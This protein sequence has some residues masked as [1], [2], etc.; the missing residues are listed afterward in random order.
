[1][2]SIAMLKRHVSGWVGTEYARFLCGSALC[3][4]INIAILIS[5]DS[6]GLGYV[7]L[8]LLAYAVSGTTGYFYHTAITFRKRARWID[9][10]CFLGGLLLGLPVW[11]LIMVV[12]RDL[13]VLHMWIA[14]PSAT[15]LMLF[16]H[17][18]SARFAVLRRLRA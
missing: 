12:L 13:L 4:T 9:Y 18:I 10:L 17:F 16:Y 15:A 14:A 3:G 7:V 2:P 1:M 8:S 6:L 11:L 5:G